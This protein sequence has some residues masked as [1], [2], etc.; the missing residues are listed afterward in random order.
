[1]SCYN[2]MYKKAPGLKMTGAILLL[3]WSFATAQSGRDY[4][5][6]FYEGNFHY[7]YEEYEKALPYFTGLV[8][9]YPDNANLNYK[10]GM[11]LLHI[12]GYESLAVPYLEKA[13]NHVKKRYRDDFHREMSAPRE[14][15]LYLGM[16]CRMN[17]DLD[18]ALEHFARYRRWFGQNDPETMEA[19]RQIKM[20]ETAKRFFSAPVSAP[21][22]EVP[23]INTAT[24]VY[25]PCLAPDGS[26]LAFMHRKD[27]Y[28]AVMLSEKYGNTWQEP[29]NITAS[30]ESDGYFECVSLSGN[31]KVLFLTRKQDEQYDLYYS[32][33]KDGRWS[34]AK[35]LESVNTRWNET[36]A[37]LTDDGNTLYFSSDR[38][39]GYGG[40][41]LYTAKLDEE[42]VATGL[43]LLDSRINTPYEETSPYL[44][45]PDTLFF[46][47]DGHVT[48]GGLD[49]V[50]SVRSGD[51]WTVPQNPGYPVNS[52]LND[53]AFSPAPGN[54]DFILT[55]HKEPGT[56]QLAW[57]MPPQA[58]QPAQVMVSGNV[59]VSS[60]TGRV[61]PVET[62]L[63][64]TSMENGDTLLVTTDSTGHFMFHLPPAIYEVTLQDSSLETFTQRIHITD[65]E[66]SHS[67]DISAR[68]KIRGTITLRN[69]YF[70]FD[71]SD[72]LPSSESALGGLVAILERF[73][74]LKIEI[75]G[76]TDAIGAEDYNLRLSERRAQTVKNYLVKQ[77]IPQNRLEIKALGESC[78]IAPNHRPDGSDNPEGRKFNRRVDFA[79]PENTYS[80]I[81]PEKPVF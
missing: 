73:P 26:A 2:E 13:T 51:T 71:R 27:Y 72:P 30:I 17:G 14:A 42:F 63:T 53:Q 35:P 61:Y 81:Q 12:P 76:H 36:T 58:V 15:F 67:L 28:R 66:D 39:G 65:R 44:K 40:L 19:E 3:A 70:G 32:R 52:T 47:S 68:G 74:D 10:T 7:L 25:N 8:K 31:G 64:V 56:S 20:C 16:A 62:T 34:S 38:P 21:P 48:M 57:F 43:Q 59:N 69:I 50:R 45:H 5:K 79:V 46:A 75:R 4:Q 1:M 77:G 24:Y 60:P 23:A 54:A 80:F 33:I 6:T 41:D 22:V 9:K 18:A 29:R 55:R 49:I 37:F 78:P 11:C